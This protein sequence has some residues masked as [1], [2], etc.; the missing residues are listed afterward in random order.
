MKAS[1][2]LRPVACL[3]VA[4]VST[5]S[6]T[7]V[8]A[9]SYGAPAGWRNIPD[10][11]V[12]TDA[13]N[14]W[15]SSGGE[16]VVGVDSTQVYGGHPSLKF[17]ITQS[18]ISWMDAGLVLAE[19]A[20][21]DISGYLPNGYL[22]FNVKGKVGGEQFKIGVVDHFG[23]RRPVEIKVTVPV[24]TYASVT[25]TWK[26]VRIPLSA[27]FDS[28]SGLDAYGAKAIVLDRVNGQPFTVWLNQ[29]KLTTTDKEK[30]FPAI[31]VNQV[32]YLSSAQKQ[33]KVS[34][35]EDELSA[36]V[37]TPFQVRRKS[38]DSVAYSGQ[39]ALVKDYDSESGERVLKA[40]FTDLKETGEYYLTVDA[41]G[42]APSLHFKIGKG[43]FTPL[44]ADA[45]RYY[46]YQRS[47]MDI[48]T[49][50]HDFPRG[51][52]LPLDHVAVFESN[53]AL[54]KDV[55]KGWFD[56]GDKGKWMASGAAAATTQLWSYELFP[57][58]YADNT[59]IPESGNGVPD[60]LD[61]VR[62]E[63]EWIMKMQD[64][65]GGIYGKVDDNESKTKRVIRDMYNGVA[66]VKPTNDTA[67]AATALAHGFFAYARFD[68]AFA[69]ACLNAAKRAWQYLEDHPNNI[70]GPGYTADDDKDSRLGAAGALFRATGEIKYNTYFQANYTRTQSQFENAHGDWVGAPFFAFCD[71]VQATNPDA[72]IVN[73]FT[74]RFG[75]YR[76]SRLARYEGN[77]WGNAIHNGNYYW[78]SNNIV[79]GTALEVMVG[80]KILGIYDA[81]AKNMAL[82]AL[83]YAL[84]SNAMRKSLVTGYG[85]DCIRTVFNTFNDYPGQGV[86]KGWIP[87]G[88]NQY[89]GG[90]SS[91]F[92][93]KDYLDSSDEWT[94]NEHSVGAACN[95]M[96]IA[97]FALGHDLTDILPR[98]TLA[99]PDPE[100]IQLEARHGQPFRDHTI[101]VSTD[102]VGW[103]EYEQ[104]PT[105]ANGAFT[106]PVKTPN[107]R[108][109][110]RV[111]VSE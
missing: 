29:I 83:N 57:H 107:D 93:A 40:V 91:N 52:P 86:P 14:G 81:R 30:G 62:W 53:P 74:T 95:L 54:T 12:F 85:E 48:T 92:P 49:Q 96:F 27:I 65:D 2:S 67:L 23:Q 17:S 78:G 59:N 106:E 25:T 10:H 84:G 24:S 47:G 63:L 15:A 9:A 77:A 22:Q 61:E 38:D 58:S 26:S 82:D 68:P 79:I 8:D 33:A 100:S 64:T 41:V 60:V 103:S 28:A 108:L 46:F 5:I 34:G 94:T 50:Y 43:L 31:K 1:Y 19:W 75:T 101:E 72:A 69:N 90:G 44:L 76:S 55:S 7:T 98:V 36:T 87:L 56:A 39:L 66:N 109:F 70:K 11:P 37:G 45:S 105:D 32:G 97:A 104:M 21:H 80:S 18:D 102:L 110:F 20:S 35:F 111:K 71:Y 16:L 42:V 6:A 51:D 3:I 89:N 4:L 13:F 99:S 88:V 73:W